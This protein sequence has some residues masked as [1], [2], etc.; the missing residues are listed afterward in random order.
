MK[1]TTSLVKRLGIIMV[2]LCIAFLI[3]CPARSDTVGADLRGHWAEDTMKEFM[4]QGVI[5]GYEDG[6]LQPDRMISRAEFMSVV[7]RLLGL[8]ETADENYRDI[9]PNAWYKDEAAKQKLI[10]YLNELA[11]DTIDSTGDMTRE[12]TVGAIGRLT[13]LIEAAGEE[14]LAQY[15][16]NGQ[17]KQDY[18]GAFNESIKRGIIK[19]YENNTLKPKSTVTRAEMCTILKRV[20]GTRAARSGVYGN[21][22]QT[23]VVS[24]NYTISS[25]NV[26]LQNMKIVGDLIITPGAGANIN[27]D[28]VEVTGRIIVSGGTAAPVKMNDICAGE[29]IVYNLGRKV[30]VETTGRTNLPSITVETPAELKLEG[31]TRTADLTIE[32]EAGG[33]EVAVGPKAEIGRAQ[34]DG[35]SSIKGEGRIKEAII[36]VPN[37]KVESEIERVTISP[38]A[39]RANINNSDVTYQDNISEIPNSTY[40]PHHSRDT[41][42]PEMQSAEGSRSITITFSEGVYTNPDGTGALTAEDFAVTAGSGTAAITDIRHIEGDNIVILNVS[43]TETSGN[44]TVQV[45]GKADSIYDRNG[46]V[47]TETAVET[48]TAPDTKKPAAKVIM[49]ATNGFYAK[50]GDTIT[51]TITADEMIEKPSVIL[52]GKELAAAGEKKD[53]T[54][55]YEVTGTDT[56]GTVS[57]AVSITDGSKNS[58]DYAGVA[59][60]N[61][62]IIDT[63]APR[64]NIIN[65]GNVTYAQSQGTQV[66]AGTDLSGINILQYAWTTGIKPETEAWADFTKGEFLNKNGENGD[67][68][69]WIKAADN[70][71]NETIVK[72]EVFKLDNTAPTIP[73]INMDES[74]TKENRT[75]TLTAGKDELSG[76]AKIQYKLDNGEWIDY[77]PETVVTAL[78]ISN[79]RTITA[80]SIDKAGNISAEVQK[81]ARVDKDVPEMQSAAGSTSITITFSEGVYT[82][83]DGTG[84][85][86]AEDFA[87]TAGSG[88]AAITDIRHIAGENTAALN[89]SYTGTVG[90][91]KVQVTGK[92]D[93]IYDRSGNVLTETAVETGTAPDTQKPSAAV[94][95]NTNNP[96]FYAKTGDT[97]TVTITADE[98]IEKP[99][100]ILAGKEPAVAG[101]GKDWTAAYEVTVADTQGPVSIAVKITDESGNSTDYASVTGGSIVAIDTQA[102]AV[103]IKSDGNDTYMQ[104]QCTEVTVSDV[105]SGV[106]TLQY[107]WS[108]DGAEAAGWADFKSGDILSKDA[109]DGSWYLNIRAIDHACNQTTVKSKVFKLDNTS[110]SVEKAQVKGAGEIEVVFTEG[111][112]TGADGTGALTPADFQITLTT[113][114]GSVTLNSVNHTAGECT[115][116]L[117]VTYTGTSGNEKVQVKTKANNIYDQAGNVLAETTAE[118]GT[119][120]DT[121]APDFVSGYP[122]AATGSNAGEIN[123]SVKVNEAAA[124]YYTALTKGAPA[125]RNADAVINH[126]VGEKYGS[127]EIKDVGAEKQLTISGLTPEREYDIYVVAED[128]AGNSTGVTGPC[129]A[130]AK[131]DWIDIAYLDDLAK[132]GAEEAYPLNGKYRLTRN[133]DFN[134][135][136]YYKGNQVNKGWSEGESGE[137][138]NPI[139]EF[140]GIFDGQDHI[141]SH[142]YINRAGVNNQGLFASAESGAKLKNMGLLNV[143]ITGNSCVGGMVG[144]NGQVNSDGTRLDGAS[145]VNCY[146]TGSVKGNEYIGGLLGRSSD[147]IAD[148]FAEAD[149]TGVKYVGGLVGQADFQNTIADCCA[150]GVVD[151]KTYVGGLTGINH[152]NISRSYAIGDVSGKEYIGGLIGYNGQ[153]IGIRCCY[154][155]G[156][157]A[158]DNNNVGGLIGMNLSD[159]SNC[160]AT[161][162]VSAGGKLIGGLV[163]N[164]EEGSLTY[165]YA[166]GSVKGIG[167]VGGL[168]GINSYQNTISS[169]YATGNVSGSDICSLD[170]G[171]VGG[172]VGYN[173]NQSSIINSYATGNV[174]GTRQIGGLVG[175][176]FV[177]GIIMN[178]YAT[179]NVSGSDTK[180]NSYVGGLVGYNDTGCTIMNSIAFNSKIAGPAPYNTHRIMG[181]RQ[182]IFKMN[183]ANSGMGLPDGLILDKEYGADGEDMI[184]A[185]FRNSSKPPLSSWDFTNIW[186]FRDGADRPTLAVRDSNGKLVY[187]GNDS[188]ELS[189]AK[190]MFSMPSMLLQELPA[191][192]A[193]EENAAP[194]AA[195]DNAEVI[196]NSSILIDVL[197]ND[198][199]D[200][201]DNLSITGFTQGENGTVVQEVYQICYIPDI[202]FTGE[203]CFMYEI[204]DGSNTAGGVVTVTVSQAEVVPPACPDEDLP[205]AGGAVPEDIEDEAELGAGRPTIPDNKQ[206]A[207]KLIM[208]GVKDEPA[209]LQ[210]PSG[211]AKGDL[212]LNLVKQLQHK[213]VQ[214]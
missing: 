189:G 166:T 83:A 156:N 84:A 130:R 151:G 96:S 77:I 6:T 52:A 74:W 174:K 169:C 200:D 155:T 79:E 162:S 66:T 199:D 112:Y 183:Y 190:D 163:G 32:Q 18:K 98:K 181:L 20:F 144:N 132:I 121:K 8:D 28:N 45:T 110:P 29:L 80:R 197:A 193:A 107:A 203:D 207:E 118:A 191:P 94:V 13:R 177:E 67:W 188:G 97:I 124:V 102:P 114:S 16:D 2:T 82:N 81:T 40:K 47:L 7:N 53:W 60:G 23:K 76:I 171:Y 125:P 195:D 103:E 87:I 63:A 211:T 42:A 205:A 182:G 105:I 129:T 27:L 22:E 128:S 78:D 38:Q 210:E 175:K 3:P 140:T 143:N 176:N 153:F 58:T 26:T 206:G 109:A 142:L 164:H 95:M 160:Y 111:V 120:P 173:G 165:C 51:V 73:I 212:Q 30:T 37:V 31:S 119:A 61:N 185:D 101:E 131:T 194:R 180:Y 33:T 137:G 24:G 88:T 154:A 186:N 12:E 133:L 198:T 34:I 106:Q 57:I 148:C 122:G 100:V 44:E 59:S 136:A 214:N 213:E 21:S 126:T 178:T 138:W 152:G 48:G 204:T 208:D 141:I 150:T 35:Q 17:I 69:L 39:G 113:G 179:G 72:S 15:K 184:K 115:A 14:N 93:S 90:D 70:A 43:Y 108:K 56:Q 1:K 99:A 68:Y 85:L 167:M 202:N 209:E 36:N 135:P 4:A 139:G 116:V 196:S 64:I 86:T 75:F 71:G 10:K 145:L 170:D 41:K 25:Q 201:G 91:E 172:L 62:I 149:I 168:A 46:N 157:V 55:V 158:A 104:N 11:D 50:T 146:A 49:T 54:A 147:S 92:A 187:L 5:E 19:G 134:Y 65:N 117:N 192:P 127:M 9:S 159:V 123:L 89:V 161:G